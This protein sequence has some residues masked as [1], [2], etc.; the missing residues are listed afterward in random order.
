MG[1]IRACD[2]RGCNNPAIYRVEGKYPRE[3]CLFHAYEIIRTPS[4]TILIC[5]FCREPLQKKIIEGTKEIGRENYTMEEVMY[6]DNLTCLNEH[7]NAKGFKQHD[8]TLPGYYFEW[9]CTRKIVWGTLEDNNIFL[10]EQ[11]MKGERF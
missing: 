8:H 2:S 5:P 11:P 10:V 7:C 3:T 9:T 4:K 1:L 6:R